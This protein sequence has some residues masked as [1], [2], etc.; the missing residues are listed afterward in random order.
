M[1]EIQEREIQKIEKKISNLKLIFI[2]GII[3]CIIGLVG[4]IITIFRT[5]QIQQ[6]LDQL[7]RELDEKPFSEL[8]EEY[9]QEHEQRIDDMNQELNTIMIYNFIFGTLLFVGPLMSI[10]TFNHKRNLLKL[11]ESNE[12]NL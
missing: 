6:E 9:R 4:L 8:T 5:T 10:T 12:I 2:I 11:I 1:T 7:D 3:I